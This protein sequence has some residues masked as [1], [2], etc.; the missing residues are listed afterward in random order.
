MDKAPTDAECVCYL[1]NGPALGAQSL[2]PG[3]IDRN[4]LA[5]YPVPL[6]DDWQFRP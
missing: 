2:E 6:A 4:R 3:G 5:A 1:T